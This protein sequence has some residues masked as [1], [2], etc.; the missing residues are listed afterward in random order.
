M[1]EQATEAAIAAVANKATGIGGGL[2]IYGGWAASDIA[3]FGGLLIAVIGIIVQVYYKRKADKRDAAA[4]ARDAA[5]ELR[6]VAEHIRRMA[7]LMR[8]E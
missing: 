4:D 6:D 3:A 5:Q 1:N 7:R 8:D 2:A